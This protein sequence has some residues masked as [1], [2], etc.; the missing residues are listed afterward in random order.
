MLDANASAQFSLKPREKSSAKPLAAGFVPSSKP[1]CFLGFFFFFP[2][3]F[4]FSSSYFF[5]S[6]SVGSSF[7]FE[8]P[9]PQREL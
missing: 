4:F 8:M 6:S 3:A 5:S 1:I 9:E 2:P 7:F